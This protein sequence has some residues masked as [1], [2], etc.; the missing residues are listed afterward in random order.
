MHP[1]E[2]GKNA[3]SVEYVPIINPCPRI[4]SHVASRGFPMSSTIIGRQI[5]RL[6]RDNHLSGFRPSG[7]YHRYA[8]LLPR[9]SNLMSS[10]DIILCLKLTLVPA[11]IG[12][13]T[14]AGRRWGAAVAGWLSSLP[15]VAGPILFFVAM[16]H[17]STFAAT[18]SIGT[19]SAIPAL[20]AFGIGYAW[21][22]T[23]YQWPLS[24]LAGFA[25]YA[26]VVGGLTISP[27]A[28]AWLGPSVIAALLLAPYLY[29]EPPTCEAISLSS[30]WDIPL[31]MATGAVLVLLV[32]HFAARMGPRLSGIFAMFP[33]MSSV[34][35]AFSHRYSGGAFAIRL[36]RGMV[37]G[38]YAFSAFCLVLS[39]LLPSFGITPAFLTALGVAL[40]IQA[41]SRTQLTRIQQ[42]P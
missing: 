11:L 7:Y 27:P 12:G 14:L 24:L 8:R 10:V 2:K 17:G 13:V 26:L 21:T 16:E 15:V 42:T 33:V 40:L 6:A 39:L 28:I 5:Y 18:A 19:F 30:S 36:L 38:Y 37:L 32:T 34:L 25:V 3:S 22:A 31:R 1:P 20:L 35:V 23:K 29:P 9:C 41:V 4:R